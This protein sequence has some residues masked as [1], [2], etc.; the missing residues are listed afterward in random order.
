M[1]WTVGTSAVILNLYIA[2][3]NLFS[4]K[5]CKTSVALLNKCLVILISLGDFLVGLYLLL[6]SLADAFY[7]NDYCNLEGE[8]LT[9]MKCS[10]LGIISTI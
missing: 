9:S 5:K 1:S 4:L 8:W 10:Y 3:R 2:A 6:I 7:R